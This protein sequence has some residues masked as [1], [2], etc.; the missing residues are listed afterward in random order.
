MKQW[1]IAP[2]LILSFLWLF[3]ASSCQKPPVEIQKAHTISEIGKLLSATNDS[4]PVSTDRAIESAHKAVSMARS[5]QND[6][7]L[8]QSWLVLGDNFRLRGENDEAFDFFQDALDLS[9]KSGYERG[10]CQSLIE[11][12]TIFY[13]RGQFDK[14]GELFHIAL[15]IAQKKKYPDLEANALNQI[16]KY[17]HTTGH[18]EESVVYYQ[19]AIAIYKSLGNSQ[20]SVSVLLS[21]GKTYNNDGNFYMALKYCLDA[22]DACKKTNDFVNLADVCNHLGTVYLSLNQ[23]DKSMEYHR[24]ALNY[25]LVLNTP[26]GLANSYN[27]IGKV[28]LVKNQPDSAQV[29][30]SKALSNCEQIGYIKGKVKALTNLG[31]VESL[32]ANFQDAER[33]LLESISISRNSGYVAG[34]AEASLE[35]GNAYLGLHKSDSARQF[36][37]LS[38]EKAK[39]AN[40]VQLDHD[41]YWGLYQCSLIEKDF[42]KS[43]EYYTLFAQSEKELMQAEENQRL[44]ELR[45]SFETET[46][47]KDNEMLRK[48]IEFQKLSILRKDAFMWIFIAALGFTVA[49]SAM[50]YFRFENKKNANQKLEQLNNQITL[51][52][53]EL[54][55]LNKEL[56]IANREKDKVFSIITHELRNPLFW[57]KNLTEMLS[58]K[59]STMQPDKVQKT[60]GTLDESAKNAFHL[61]DNLLHW[62]RSRLNRITPVITEHS[63]EKLVTESSRMYETIL[64]QKNIRLVTNLSGDSFI[65]ADAD[66]FMCVVRNLVSNAIKFTPE[67]GT[68]EINSDRERQHYVIS[69]SDSGIGI[70]RKHKKSIFNSEVNSI[71]VG[72]MNEKGSGFGLKLCKEFVKMNRGK[73]WVADNTAEGG[74]CFCFTVPSANFNNHQA[75]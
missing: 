18:F 50:F 9:K 57:F 22:L 75:T 10:N 35:L 28:F 51:K 54:E 21:L 44:S 45:I 26:E 70:D 24:K 56:E 55:K 20:Q 7:L 47:E 40:L 30:F 60:L 31:K 8:I 74:S 1:H 46:K 73:I 67:N 17:L 64:K 48:Y 16:G 15:E 32:Q 49:F 5:I 36:F 33:Y 69:V 29:Y 63:L 61:M 19:R 37:Q 6:T 53:Q 14:S 3:F 68:I 23:P 4:G 12:G 2:A 62:S 13:I 43:L 25:R 39:L 52:N 27:N 34:I 11:S 38:L 42:E 66:L 71:S 59:Y 41:G 65:R 58:L 72:L